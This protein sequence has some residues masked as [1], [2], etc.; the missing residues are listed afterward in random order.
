MQ[1]MQQTHPAIPFR[2]SF[3]NAL[4]FDALPP[5]KRT[6]KIGLG[7]LIDPDRSLA[8]C[9]LYRT[10]KPTQGIPATDHVCR[11]DSI[12]QVHRKRRIRWQIAPERLLGITTGTRYEIAI[13]EYHIR[14]KRDRQV[15]PSVRRIGTGAEHPHQISLLR[16]IGLLRQIV[17]VNAD[18]YLTGT[19]TATLPNA[20]R[21]ARWFQQVLDAR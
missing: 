13:T 1:G 20:N 10:G 15:E 8:Y 9:Q 3:T 11:L 5:R 17:K 4:H 21:R 16:G 18:L 7:N 6:V 12:M 14:F 2:P 19:T